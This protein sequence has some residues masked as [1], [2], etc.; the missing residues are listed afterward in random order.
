MLPLVSI[1][2]PTYNRPRLLRECLGAIAQEP[3]PHKEV[4][5]VN[6]AGADV[7][8][9]VERFGRS[10][11]VELI[12]FPDNRYH[13]RARNE[14]VRKSRGD[15]IALCD[16][17]DILLPGHLSR[18]VQS[19]REH[20]HDLH[21]CDAEIVT[22]RH[23]GGHRQPV[24][25]APFAFDFDRSLIRRWN[26]VI[27][28]SLIYDRRLHERVGL[29]DESVRDYWDW[30]FVLRACAVCEVRRT[31][32][33]GV[34]YFVS[35]TGGNLSGDQ[36]AM[37]RSFTRFCNKHALADL[38]VSSFHAMLTEPALDAYRRPTRLV[39]DGSP[40]L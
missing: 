1:I 40:L 10:L 5:I 17:D 31:S 14:G 6:D 22:Y 8:D 2:I 36:A 30:D 20:P 21:F 33:A 29:F 23:G 25:R 35:L 26:T 13:V 24:R 38:P 27:P 15:L 37:T 12:Q 3:Y 7:S 19:W 32:V 28:S 39:W 9:V 4:V 16:D 18:M 34:L 11:R